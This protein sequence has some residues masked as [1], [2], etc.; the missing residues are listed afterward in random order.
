EDGMGDWSVTGVETCARPILLVGHQFG[1]EGRVLAFAGDTTV[2]WKRPPEGEVHHAR[3]WRQVVLW[4]A[5]QEERAGN[6]WVRP[7]ARRVRWGEG[8]VGEEMGEAGVRGDR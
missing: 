3:F 7:D 2:R 5:K 4:L 1:K 6:V 8:R